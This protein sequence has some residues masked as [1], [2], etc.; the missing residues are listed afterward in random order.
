VDEATAEGVAIVEAHG[1]CLPAAHLAETGVTGLHGRG[2]VVRAWARNRTVP[3]LRGRSGSA[4]AHRCRCAEKLAP[5]DRRRI[6]STRRP[7]PDAVQAEPAALSNHCGQAFS[8]GQ[9]CQSIRCSW[10]GRQRSFAASPGGWFVMCRR[11][12]TVE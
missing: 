4:E 10:P 12:P 5:P 11:S 3:G 9:S 2:P 7:T 1:Q 8:W 6:G